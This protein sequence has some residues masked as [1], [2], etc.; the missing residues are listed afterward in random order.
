MSS[1]SFTFRGHRYPF[2]ANLEDAIR[3]FMNGLED[4]AQA[5]EALNSKVSG[6]TTAATAATSTTTKKTTTPATPAAP[7]N[8]DDIEDGTIWAKIRASALTNGGLVDPRSSSMI[9]YGSV[10]V[11]YNTGFTYTSNTTSI[12]WS[13]TL[14]GYRTDRELTTFNETSSQAVT[15]LTSATTY[16]FY[17][18]WDDESQYLSMVDTGVGTPAW[19][20]TSSSDRSVS[21]AQSREDRI[22]LSLNPMSAATTSSGTGGGSGG[23]DGGCLWRGMLVK[24]KT[25]G[26]IQAIDVQIGDHL[27]SEN[28]SWLLVTD[29]RPSVHDLWVIIRWNNQAASITTAGHPFTKFEDRQ[30]VRASEMT[31]ETGVP[32][33]TGEAFPESMQVVRQNDMKVSITLEAPHVFYAS[34]DGVNWILTHNQIAPTY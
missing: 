4:H 14:T 6:E 15:G 21:A 2:P 10:P 12:T 17:P 34:M 23:G 1:K 27:W 19:A 22:A 25:K 31:L 16:Y 20:Y 9:K 13:W 30:T 18:Y 28:D 26:V 8:M 7:I 24:E 11:T 32:C 3:L 5:I 29:V 33:P